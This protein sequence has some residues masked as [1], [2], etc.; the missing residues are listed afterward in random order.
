MAVR[1]TSERSKIF[2]AATV[3]SSAFGGGLL[4]FWAFAVGYGPHTAG[5]TV[6]GIVIGG[7]SALSASGCAMAFFQGMDAHATAVNEAS[8]TDALTGILS[9]RQFLLD[10][11]QYAIERQG[12][13]TYFVDIELN[14]FKQ[15][16]EAMG[17]R[18]GDQLIRDCSERIK[19]L[20]PAGALFG[21]L[22]A[23]EFGL[24][25]PDELAVPALEIQLDTILDDVCRPYLIEDRRVVVSIS[26]GVTEFGMENLEQAAILKRANLALH[27]SRGLGRKQW[28]MFEPELGRIADHRRWLE[29][30]MQTALDRQD[31]EL[32]YQPQLDLISGDVVGYEALVRWRHPDKGLIPPND[33]IPVAEDTGLIAPLGDWVLRRACA[34]A[35]HLPDNT[36]VAVNLSA[37]QFL[38]SDMVAAVRAA[39]ADSGLPPRRL[40]L[41]I[42]ESLLMEDREKTGLILGELARMGVSVAV[43]DFGTGYSNLTYLADLPFQKL[44]IDRSFVHRLEKGGNTGAIISTIV[45]LSRA[46]G[47]HTTAEGVETADQADLLRAAGCDVGQ[48]FFY[49]RPAPIS[50]R[51]I[52]DGKAPQNR[53]A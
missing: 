9:R 51:E 5:T 49:G 7:L 27:R 46:L 50:S 29:A 24:V 37:A 25:I 47:V 53:A 1:L 2:K 15:L 52:S 12:K 43:D 38:L 41:E 10:L 40:E 22:G 26:A 4:G 36:F 17:F 31:F 3:L 45:G 35:L 42:T 13:A 19:A 20:L 44:K 30:E 14:R 16:N 39:L 34:D 48:G 11:D 21:R 6:S 18:T 8:A 23:C 32:H 28:S 33:F